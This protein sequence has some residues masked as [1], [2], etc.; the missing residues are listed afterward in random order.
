MRAPATHLAVGP[1]H[2]SLAVSRLSDQI[3]VLAQR[4]GLVEQL[5]TT[6]ESRQHGS[7]RQLGAADEL[8]EQLERSAPQQAAH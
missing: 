6:S 1:A 7:R 4:L 2:F 3:K 5:L 8:N